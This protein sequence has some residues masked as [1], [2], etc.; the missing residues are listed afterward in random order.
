MRISEVMHVHLPVLSP[1]STVREAVDKMD[2]YQFPA[3]VIV[4]DDRAP[5]GV[6]TESRLAEAV[7]LIPVPELAFR[8]AIEFADRSPTVAEVKDEIQACLHLMIER[9]IELLPVVSE[10]RLMG[11]ALRVDLLQALFTALSSPSI[12]G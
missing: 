2:I 12:E 4:D 7:K 11:V 5:I 3:L 1:A 8:A 10:G 6:I 9:G